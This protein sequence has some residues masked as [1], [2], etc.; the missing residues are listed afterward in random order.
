MP[1][2]RKQRALITGSCFGLVHWF[3]RITLLSILST[4]PHDI[5]TTMWTYIVMVNC[6]NKK[7]HKPSSKRGMKVWILLYQCKQANLL[8]AQLFA[9]LQTGYLYFV[10]LNTLAAH[11]SLFPLL[12]VEQ[13]AWSASHMV[14]VVCWTELMTFRARNGTKLEALT[15][16]SKWKTLNVYR[17]VVFTFLQHRTY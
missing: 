16:K 8:L 17:L 2:V 7:F 14:S 9:H 11:R 15:V 3:T 5:P 13:V 6:Q 4:N 10:T 12:V 1:Y